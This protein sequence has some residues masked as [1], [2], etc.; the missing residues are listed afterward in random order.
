MSDLVANIG[1]ILQGNNQ[2]FNRN[3][4]QVYVENEEDVPFWK[5]FFTKYDI[6]TSVSP[7]TKAHL[8]GGKSSVL[9]FEKQVNRSFL[10]CVDSDNDYIM[11]G[12]AA[13]SRR[14]I[15]NPYIFETYLYA[16][17]SYRCYSKYLHNIVVDAVLADERIFDFEFFLEQYSEIIYELFIKFIYFEK[18]HQL[19]FEVYKQKKAILSA[20]D[21][22]IWR[23][24]YNFTPH[25]FSQNSNFCPAIKILTPIKIADNGQSALA[26]LKIKVD[27]T[28]ANL[29]TVSQQDLDKIK[30]DLATLGITPQNTYLFIQGH[31][32]YDNVVKPILNTVADNLKNK[33]MAE[34]ATKAKDDEHA[35]QKR[36]E[37]KKLVFKAKND[38][39]TAVERTWFNAKYYAFCPFASKIEAD[40]KR[41]IAL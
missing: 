19:E 40:I 23:A 13:V 38:E 10:L 4:V 8:E 17:E 2:I 11:Q 30:T 41:Y 25:I 22:L 6:E 3:T 14:V 35:E 32:L 20:E 18:I 15:Q 26:D 24:Q 7:A 34:F 16:M 21:F 37:Y 9:S 29:P 1:D 31:T 28:Y 33:K 27:T 36:N 5:Y 12:Q 39:L